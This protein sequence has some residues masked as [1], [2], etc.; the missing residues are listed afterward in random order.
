MIAVNLKKGLDKLNVP[1]RFNDYSY[2]KQHPEEV[3]CIIGMPQM[4]FNRQWD[5][6]V[7]LGAGVFSHPVECPDLFSEYPNVKRVLVPGEWMRKM[8]EPYYNG[9]VLSWPVGI[10]TDRWSKDMKLE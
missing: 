4:L 7:I 6:P 10:D 5:N 1:Y 2:I 8:F 9:Q 3:A